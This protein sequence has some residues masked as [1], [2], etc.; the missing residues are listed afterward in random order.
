MFDE[1][2]VNANKWRDGVSQMN[3]KYRSILERIICKKGKEYKLDIMKHEKQGNVIALLSDREDYHLFITIR[4]ELVPP[5][6]LQYSVTIEADGV[7][8]LIFPDPIMVTEP[9]KD[10]FIRFANQVNRYCFGMGKFWVDTEAYDIAYEV[11]VPEYCLASYSEEAEKQLF[12]IPLAHWNDMINP[13]TMLSKGEW[14]ADIAIQYFNEM[15]EQGCV[16]NREYGL[17]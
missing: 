7:R 9:T 3:Q 4:N 14:N 2:D 6:K 15:H 1:E 11:I 13:V 12:D 16:D 17:W 10:N 8:C 5:L